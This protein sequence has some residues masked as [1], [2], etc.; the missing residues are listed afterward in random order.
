MYIPNINDGACKGDI[1]GCRSLFYNIVGV[2]WFFN[3][4]TAIIWI[5]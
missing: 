2:Y 3:I 5:S 1:V 4:K